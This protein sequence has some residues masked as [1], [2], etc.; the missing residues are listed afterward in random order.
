MVNAIFKIPMILCDDLV[1]R[2]YLYET[3]IQGDF[4]W[5]PISVSV[6]FSLHF[7]TMAPEEACAVA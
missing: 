1:T 5:D 3:V 4:R 7:S 6:N 2:T